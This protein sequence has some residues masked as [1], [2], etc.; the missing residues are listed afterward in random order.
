MATNESVSSTRT[1]PVEFAN[2]SRKAFNHENVNLESLELVWLTPELDR[3]TIILEV[4]RNIIHYTKFFDSIE[5]CIHFIELN[6]VTTTF[7]VCDGSLGEKLVSQ[8]YDMKNIYAIYIYS[9][10]EKYHQEWLEKYSEKFIELTVGI[11]RL[12]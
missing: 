11:E 9:Q 7:L 2:Q 1:D 8:I 3:N 10:H 4:L 12:V 5:E 6:K